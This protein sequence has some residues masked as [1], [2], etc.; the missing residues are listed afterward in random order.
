MS[1]II[2]GN[3]LPNIPFEELFISKIGTY[4]PSLPDV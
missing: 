2:N 3:P 4:V 1:K